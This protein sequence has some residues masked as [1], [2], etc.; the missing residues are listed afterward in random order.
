MRKNNK[1]K[2]RLC[3]SEFRPRDTNT[4]KNSRGNQGMQKI[5]FMGKGFKT[6]QLGPIYK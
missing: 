6:I 4:R 3:Y 5:C 2:I 1:K